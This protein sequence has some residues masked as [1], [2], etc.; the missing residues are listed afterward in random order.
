MN[1]YHIP[2]F[3]LLVLAVA[4][5]SPTRN[6]DEVITKTELFLPELIPQG[7]L[8][9][10]GVFSSDQKEYYFTVSDVDFGVFTVMYAQ[11]SGDVWSNPDTAF[12][13]SQ[14]LEHGVHFSPDGQWLYFSSTR[15]S[16]YDTVADTW[17]IWRSK[18]TGN[19]W[20]DPEFVDLPGFGQKLTSHPS[21]TKDGRLYFHAGNADYSNLSL[22]FADQINGQFLEPVKVSI[23][24]NM[25]T[26]TLTPFI[27]PDETFLLFSK[28]IDGNEFLFRCNRK[29]NTWGQAIK[30]NIDHNSDNLSNP[31]VTPDGQ[32][33]LYASGEISANGLP[34]NWVIKQ[35]SAV[36]LLP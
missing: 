20:S 34:S 13:N 9:H 19:S 30:L 3:L 24:D 27:S 4:C 22:Y 25:N 32:K 8:A 6:S 23:P 33:L 10:A 11:Q 16:D 28:I 29:N 26:N 35:V 36:N 14:F 31:F 21:L 1:K 5:K 18:R 2:I 7:L 17:H 12:F 15:T